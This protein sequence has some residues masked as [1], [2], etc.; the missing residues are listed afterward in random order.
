MYIGIKA[1]RSKNPI[2]QQLVKGGTALLGSCAFL[3][4]LLAYYWAWEVFENG[5]LP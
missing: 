3:A 5:I 4:F 1:E 2:R